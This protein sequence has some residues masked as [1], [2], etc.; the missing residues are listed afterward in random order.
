VGFLVGFLF[1]FILFLFS[2]LAMFSLNQSAS[3]LSFL[4]VGFFHILPSQPRRIL[5][6]AS[7]EKKIKHTLHG[8]YRREDG[9]EQTKEKKTNTRPHWLG[10]RTY[11]PAFEHRGL[12][13]LQRGKKYA[14]SLSIWMQEVERPS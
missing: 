8:T 3:A 1:Y 9:Q 14:G 5:N 4:S 13:C 11:T 2:F 12:F 6:R 10:Q 7:P